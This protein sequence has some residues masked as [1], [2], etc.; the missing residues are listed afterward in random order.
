LH[1][2]A[3][4]AGPAAIVPEFRW[5]LDGCD[6]ADTLVLN[7]HK[8]LFVPIDLSVLYA[9]DLEMVRRAFTLSAD[10]LETPEVG[11]RNYMDYGL[12]LGRRFRA[13]KL[14]FVLRRYGA[15]AIR[16]ILRRHIA[17][18]QEL[19]DWVEAEPAWTLAAPHPLSV[20]CFRYAPDGVRDEDLDRGNLAVME[21]VNASGEAFISS[22]KLDGRVVLRVAIGNE[23]TTREDVRAVWELL[24]T[25][26]VEV[27]PGAT[28]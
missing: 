16:N 19:A 5:L 3:A 13:L 24:R 21:A 4:Y 28:R 10:Y 26:A 17:L 27:F 8:W 9:R 25:A 1:V 7:P 15:E 6:R 14:W 23:R 11:V 18:A 12:Q 20:V 22:T 2:D